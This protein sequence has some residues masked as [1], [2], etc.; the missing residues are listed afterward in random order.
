MIKLSAEISCVRI[1]RVSMLLVGLFFIFSLPT[2][3]QE[4]AV[5][6]ESLLEDLGADLL[7]PISTQPVKPLGKGQLDEQLL[8]QLGENGGDDIGEQQAAGDDWLAKVVRSMRTAQSLL[9]Q[10]EVADSAS[11]AQ[12]DALT[13]LD[14]MI[15]ELTERKSKCQGGNCQKPGGSKPGKKKGKSGKTGKNAA[16]DSAPPTSSDADLSTDLAVAGQL[17]KD[18][19]GKLPERQREQILQ[20][21][22]EEFLPKYASEIEAYYRALADPNRPRPEAP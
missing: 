16:E 18:L 15:A 3:A 14:A 1:W 10:P 2:Q 21:L 17:V 8:E 9:E 20:P 5:S 4:E 7:G 22:S 6:D 13:G 19:W 12:M 11:S